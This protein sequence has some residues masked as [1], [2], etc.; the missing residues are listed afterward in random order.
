MLYLLVFGLGTIAGMMLMTAAI[1]LPFAYTENRFQRLSAGLRVAAG[2]LSVAFG[3]Y[4]AYRVGFVDGL[5]TTG[6]R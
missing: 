2:V 3:L 6:Q 5:F 4:L 1:V